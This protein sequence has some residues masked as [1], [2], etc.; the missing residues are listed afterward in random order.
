MAKQNDWFE[1]DKAGL[2]KLVDQVG[3]HRLIME[4][5]SNA[6]DEPGVSGVTVEIHQHNNPARTGIV[7]KDDAPAGFADLA[8]A[9]TLFAESK[10]KASANLRGRFNLGE[11]LVLAICSEAWIKTTTGTVLFNAEGRTRTRAKSESGSTFFGTMRMTRDETEE[12]FAKLGAMICPPGIGTTIRLIDQY[13][14]II[15][16]YRLQPP[17]PLRSLSASLPVPIADEEG[18]LRNRKC[19]VVVDVIPVERLHLFPY[20]T[21]GSGP[22]IVGIDG[23]DPSSGWLFEMGIPVVEIGGP[24]HINVQAKVPLNKDRDNVP[25]SY[26]AALRAAVLDASYIDLPVA[27]ARESWVKEALSSVG[28][29]AAEA[30]MTKAFGEKRV[31]FDPSDPEA[32]RRAAAH[33]YTVVPGGALPSEAWAN[34]RETKAIEPAG[35]IFK[36]KFPEFSADGIDTEIPRDQ[37][38]DGMILATTAMAKIAEALIGFPVKMRIVNDRYNRF[39]AWYSTDIKRITFNVAVLGK[40]WFDPQPEHASRIL[41]EAHIDLLLHELGH[42]I[43]SNHLDDR[44]HAALTSL[45]AKLAVLVAINPKVRSCIF[46]ER[47]SDAS[48]A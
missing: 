7:V 20:R 44:Y 48:L 25:P 28:A 42:S 21:E 31:A 18:Y 27:E 34:V 12:A 41:T 3:K 40:R 45:G 5:V 47:K 16:E 23:A 13:G 32:N 14:D 43:E 11:K 36:T 37:W 15:A 46:I 35:R 39:G 26:L 24:W 1:V 17:E 10:K 38:T 30:V 29:E 4:L 6:W 2:A 19:S 22:K 8:H 9:W 33:G